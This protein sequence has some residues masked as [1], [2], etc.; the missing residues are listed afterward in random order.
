MI[1]ELE[2]KVEDR[3]FDYVAEAVECVPESVSLATLNEANQNY[4]RSAGGSE[5][6]GK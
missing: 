1:E 2:K 5:S 3:T 4:W 6:G